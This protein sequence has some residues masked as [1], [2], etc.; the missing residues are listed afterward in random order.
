MEEAGREGRLS[1]RRVGSITET[2]LGVSALQYFSAP[3][4]TK[5]VRGTEETFLRSA[6]GFPEGGI[7]L[8]DA[9]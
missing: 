1:Q 4:L 2:T 5:F 9:S 3:R 7:D 6:T 8:N